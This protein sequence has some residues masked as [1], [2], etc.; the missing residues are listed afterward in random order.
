MPTAPH[1]E[2]H[3]RSSESVRDVV[4]GMADGL[5]VPF[6]LDDDG[7]PVGVQIVARPWEEQALLELGVALE[8]ARGP[9]GAPPEP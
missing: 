7:M 1:V 5:T 9:F 4:I 2:T 6:A 8:A 3:F